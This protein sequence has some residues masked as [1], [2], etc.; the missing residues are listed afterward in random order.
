MTREEKIEAWF[1]EA[2]EGY[3]EP[4]VWAGLDDDDFLDDP[5]EVPPADP[6]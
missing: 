2:F 3:V 6:E 1:R 5:G 4:Y